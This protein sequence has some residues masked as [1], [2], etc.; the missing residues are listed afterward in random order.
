MAGDSSGVSDLSNSVGGSGAPQRLGLRAARFLV[1]AASLGSKRGSRLDA[2]FRPDGGTPQQR[3]ELG[4]GIGAIALLAAMGLRPDEKN[5]VA[6]KLPAGDRL[7]AVA[8]VFRQRRA[9]QVEAQ[10]DGG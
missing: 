6:A 2:F 9:R 3:D 1:E 4:Q 8:H 7:E 10:L 5:A